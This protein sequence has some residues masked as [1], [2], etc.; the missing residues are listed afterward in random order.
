MRI[1]SI[2]ALAFISW[3][4]CFSQANQK[5]NTNLYAYAGT[6]W[7]KTIYK[8][9]FNDTIEE[10]Y[11]DDDSNRID[12]EKFFFLEK[13]TSSGVWGARV[14]H[15]LTRKFSVGFDFWFAHTNVVGTVLRKEY[16]PDTSFFSYQPTTY[17]VSTA[18]I[19][20]DLTRLNATLRFNLHF[21]RS[22]WIDPYVHGAL[23]GAFYSFITT[24]SNT[25]VHEELPLYIPISFKLG[26]GANFWLKENIAA[27]LE[28]SIGGPIISGG[29]AYKIPQKIK[30]DLKQNSY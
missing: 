13:A 25:S 10:Y 8:A 16:I 21:G 28:L 6:D 26:G 7:Y 12:V 17:T 29:I 1:I 4:N 19:S 22:R 18:T 15:F 20:K 9:Q 11:F 2:L 30:L 23:G 27:F 3:I 14:E 5:G 24:S